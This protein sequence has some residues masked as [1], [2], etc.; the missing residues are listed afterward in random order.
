VI[1]LFYSGG[2]RWFPLL[3]ALAAA[4][5]VVGAQRIHIRASAVYVSLGLVLWIAMQ[6]SGVHPAMAGVAMG[7]LTPAVAF[8]RPRTVSQEAH[9]TADETLDDPFPPDA[10]APH[11]LRLA[12]L[13]RE[14][15]SPLARIEHLLL[16]WVSFV[17]LPLFALA[18]AG[19]ALSGDAFAQAVRS[20]VAIGIVLGRVAGKVVG[21]TLACWLVVRAGIAPLPAGAR[22][23]HVVGVGA[24]AAIAF[25]VSLFIADLALPA[26][27]HDAA[28][29]GILASAIV[30]GALGYAI[31]RRSPPQSS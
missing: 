10:D 25:T 2:V 15:V 13:S 31:L 23:I 3:L 16:P 24:T 22:W 14:A 6:R 29:V 1:A 27:L 5:A 9:R 4:V 30:G 12:T 7:L 19:V 20:P 26:G 8:Q 21:I 11:W 17:I 18:N 28:K